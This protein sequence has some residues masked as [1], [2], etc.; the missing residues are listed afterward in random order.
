MCIVRAL[1]NLLEHRKSRFS[2]LL[3][4]V[5]SE[6]SHQSEYTAAVDQRRGQINV[7][8]FHC[9]VAQ[10]NSIYHWL[11]WLRWHCCNHFRQSSFGHR[12]TVFQSSIETVRRQLVTAQTRG[13]GSPYV[14]RMVVPLGS[15]IPIQPLTANRAA[16][17][18]EGNKTVGIDPTVT[19]A[20]KE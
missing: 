4:V 18:S 5:P 1:V 16:E 11:Y 15:R 8:F 9:F 6:D 3:Q 12:W 19:T 10:L 2:C 14:A 7:S 17:H 20:R 13:R